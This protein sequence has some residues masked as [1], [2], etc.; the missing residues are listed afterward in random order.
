MV[1]KETAV[2]KIGV[3]AVHTVGKNTPDNQYIVFLKDSRD[4][5]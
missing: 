3:D 2:W 1:Q 5:F 4:S